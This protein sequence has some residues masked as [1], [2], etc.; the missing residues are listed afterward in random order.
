M[1][2]TSSFLSLF[3]A[4]FLTSPS[5]RAHCE[6]SAQSLFKKVIFYKTASDCHFL[7]DILKPINQAARYF[8]RQV[9]IA[10]FVQDR[11]TNASFDNGQ[12]IWLP[13]NLYAYDDNSNAFY[14]R[15]KDLS[16]ILLHEVGHAF[17]HKRLKAELGDE[18]GDLF[19]Q[20]QNISDSTLESALANRKTSVSSLRVN[21]YLADTAEFKKYLKYVV[22]YAEL[23]ADT[24]SVL[25]FND[26][27]VMTRALQFS[28]HNSFDKPF[29]QARSFSQSHSYLNSQNALKVHT[30]FS[31]VRSYLGI[32]LKK[33]YFRSQR[34]AIL[35]ALENA[36]IQ[37]IQEEMSL[38]KL[39]ELAFR[40]PNLVRKI[41]ANLRAK[42]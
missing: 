38:E 29:I 8:S 24:V 31:F 21:S 33:T 34:V 13:K 18:F 2:S 19:L 30:E 4:L 15:K 23:Y 22:G 9:D 7:N 1:W 36:I 11:G 5:A 3:I 17:L 40:N 35:N 42:N 20:L 32:L 14:A 6:D 27:D 10:L 28:T 26:P 41:E 25:Y 12:I 39:P 16:P 37:Q